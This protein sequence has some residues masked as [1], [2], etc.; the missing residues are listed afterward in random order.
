[1]DNYIINLADF[2]LTQKEFFIRLFV[3]VGIGFLIG[4]EREYSSINSESKSFAGI[5]TFTFVVLLGFIAVLMNYLLSPWVYAGILMAVIILIGISYW[6][7]SAAGDIGGTTEFTALIAF[8][9][10][11]LSFL[12]YIELSLV[13]TVLVIVLLSAKVKFKYI[14]GK[15][16]QQEMYDLIRFIVAA[17]LIFPFLPNVAMGPFDILNP[18]E[19]GSV[20]L[21][22]SGLGFLGYLMMK[23]LGAHKGI[24]IT[25]ILGG[26]VSSTMV[27]WVFAKK[28]KEL[29]ALSINC[30]TAILAASS[31]MVL[32]VLLWVY[33]FNRSLLQGLILPVGIIF[34][35]AIGIT[36]YFYK[37]Q[38][39]NQK[40]DDALPGNK[41][42]DMQGAITFGFI[43]TMILLL[44]SYTS[45][46]FGNKGILISSVVAGLTD[47]D[48][49]TISVSKLANVNLTMGVAQ[50]AILL[51]TISNTLVKIGIA[52]YAGSKEL[53]KH[54]YIGYGIIFL[55][56]LIGFAILNA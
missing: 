31:I 45:E 3:A 53:R 9:L 19:I 28:S 54:I 33:I 15:I 24:L 39:K 48:A 50:N 6:I 52:L 51:A 8:F 40:M 27:T 37:K 11:S 43:Y 5:R 46:Y 18:K 55:A 1:M 23:F 34:L 16:T 12:G 20:I 7:T 32:R 22:I 26:L 38:A 49:I 13:I 21:L 44:V 35:G 41:P 42:L 56:A 30:A 36:F 2:Q 14:V 4:L 25:G 47:I 29:P 10:G 17:L